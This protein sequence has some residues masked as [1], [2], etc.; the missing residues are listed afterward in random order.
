MTLTTPTILLGAAAV[1]AGASW[2]LAKADSLLGKLLYAVKTSAAQWERDR[3]IEQA[4]TAAKPASATER[5]AMEQGAHEAFVAFS[6]AGG[7]RS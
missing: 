5:M 7:F 3:A 2:L 4:V 1:A 6:R